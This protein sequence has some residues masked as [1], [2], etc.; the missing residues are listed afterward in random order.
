MD[1]MYHPKYAQLE[2]KRQ[3]CRDLMGGT[4]AMRAAGETYLPKEPEESD[5]DYEIRLARSFLYNGFGHTVL[6]L[7][8][9]LFSKPVEVDG[10]PR[11]EEWAKDVT[12][13]GRDVEGFG[14][15]FSHT[16]MS[17]G[18]A[19]IFI[20]YT[21]RQ[22][23]DSRAEE[24]KLK[25]RP[26]MV[27]IKPCDLFYW[28]YEETPAGK[29]LREIKF[30]EEYVENGKELKQIRVWRSDGSWEVHREAPAEATEKWLSFA[31]GQ[32]DLEGI[33]LVTIYYGKRICPL[34]ADPPLRDLAEVNIAHWQ[35]SSDQRYVLHIARVPIL[36]TK[37]LRAPGG[38]E[39]KIVI[40]VNRHV[41]ADDPQA[42]MKYVE[43]SGQA[44]N[45]G[46][47][48]LQDLE[49]QMGRMGIELLLPNKPA[50]TTATGE[51]KSR[52]AEES[53]LQGIAKNVRRG[54]DEAFGWMEKWADITQDTKVVMNTDHD[55]FINDAGELNLLANTRMQRDISRPAFLHELKRRGVLGDDFDPVKDKALLDAELPEM[56]EL[57]EGEDDPNSDAR[58][59]TPS[60]SD[61]A[62]AEK[63]AKPFQVKGRREPTKV[64]SKLPGDYED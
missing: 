50:S 12:N 19:H 38:A 8:G 40:G 21:Q 45:A 13:D 16:G 44:I 49:A 18:V 30:Y 60:L 58:N 10:D 27:E 36:F 48:D 63:G 39:T 33:P 56:P 54:L 6:N 11:I 4:E 29:R 2:S 26:Y 52:A 34:G 9:R 14:V 41:K 31:S 17:E 51:D 46:R 61:K 62:K 64:G 3:I 32:T 22:R 15:D 42:D 55:L 53:T 25:P 1:V 24:K 37:G 43:H 23:V 20:D 35:S 47:Q 57:P 59:R 5:K 28:D 7:T